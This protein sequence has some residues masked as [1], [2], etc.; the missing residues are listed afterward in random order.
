[1]LIYVYSDTV[2]NIS[3]IFIH[4][5]KSHPSIISITRQFGNSQNVFSFHCVKNDEVE[6]VLTTLDNKKAPGHDGLQAKFLKAAGCSIIG[7]LCDIFNTCIKRNLFPAEL[8]K[9][10]ISPL[11]KKSD[12]MNKVNFRSVN[13]LP[14]LSKLYEKILGSQITDYFMDKMHMSVSAYRKGYSCQHVLIHLTEFWRQALDNGEKVAMVAMDL[15]KAFDCM[16]HG[17]VIAKLKAYGFSSDACNLI[18]TYLHNRHQRVK[19]DGSV[20]PWVSINRGVPQGTVLGPLLFNIFLNDLFYVPMQSD[21]FNYADDNTLSKSGINCVNIIENDS[22]AACEWFS[23]NYMSANPE[24]F[25]CM[26]MGEAREDSF[27]FKIERKQLHPVKQVK[28]LGVNFDAD[29]KFSSHISV[30]CSKA[31]RQLNVLKRLSRFLDEKSRFAVYKS[32]MAST[33]EYCPVVWIFCG[34]ANGRKLERLHERALRFI[35]KDNVSTYDTLLEK[36]NMLPLGLLRLRYLV[37]EVFKCI[38]GMNPTYL[39]DMFTIKEQPYNMRDQMTVFLPKFKT[40]TYGYRSFRYYG[41]KVWNSLPTNIKSATDIGTF[42]RYLDDFLCTAAA[43][44]LVIF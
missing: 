15:S 18:M 19:I 27:S 24:K 23:N 38:N 29:M 30:I 31:S 21:I 25:Q 20:S 35:Y 32:F 43:K 34:K 9:A 1:M 22:T 37:I 17:L 28:I 11:F 36:S 39:S 10:D 5:H 26:L 8:K 16:P 12:C 40:R 44:D 7:P 4:K 41:A 42:K 3:N 6:K 33:F 2:P 13:I 14:I